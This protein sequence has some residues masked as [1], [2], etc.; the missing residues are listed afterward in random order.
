MPDA[1]ID[2]QETGTRH[3]TAERVAKQLDALVISIS[4]SRDVVTVYLGDIRYIM[5]PIRV[6]LGKAD[7]ALQTLETFKTGSTRS[8]RRSRRSSSR[9]RSRCST[10]LSVLQRIEMVLTLSHLIE[11]YIIE[12]GTEG[13]LV[14]LQMEELMVNVREDRRAVLADYLPDSDSR[15]SGD[16]AGGAG[17]AALRRTA[18][19]WTSI[20]EHPGLR[21][22]T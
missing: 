8:P 19:R 1:S 10:S 11:R 7:Q 13:R 17:R 4:A 15:A 14:Q 18:S 21:I 16:G 9:T 20:G 22:R 2:S 5:D 12:L 3:R 6:I